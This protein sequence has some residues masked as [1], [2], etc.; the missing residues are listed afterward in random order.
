MNILLFGGTGR[1]GK[2]ILQKALNDGHNVTTIA[3]N[4]E[5]LDGLEARIIKGTPYDL[6]NVKQAVCDCDVV[7]STLNVS[8]VSDSPWA[9]LRSPKDMIS[10]SIHNALQVMPEHGIK[11][12]IVMSTLGA[13]DSWNKMPLI[14]KL[15]ISSSNLRYAFKDHT[16]QEQILAK[17][18]TNWTVVRLPG[19]TTEKGERE[20]KIKLNN[21]TKLNRTVNRESVARFILNIIND[22][23]YF[24][25]IAAIS[26]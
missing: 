3:R 7:I 14:F 15:V 19:L 5:S 20:V 8:R 18:G 23:R 21:D 6:E 12:I 25:N 9:K 2:I 16:R 26:N 17:S 4:P 24:K 22:E 13:G 11:R 1:T 10:H